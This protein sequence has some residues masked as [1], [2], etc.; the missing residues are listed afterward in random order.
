[1]TTPMTTGTLGTQRGH[2]G[3]R[4]A[5]VRRKLAAAT[6]SSSTLLSTA[7]SLCDEVPLLKSGVGVD[8]QGGG[9]HA[10]KGQS[11]AWTS[12][13]T[14]VMLRNI[15]NR[16]TTEEIIE[17]L[18]AWGFE[19]AFDFFY[20]PIDFKTKRNKGYSFLNFCS[21]I[22]ASRFHDTFNHRKLMKYV[23]QK[24]LETQPAA[25]QGLEANIKAYSAQAERVQNP[26]FKPMIFLHT[27]DPDKKWC[28]VSL[29]ANLSKVPTDEA[30]EPASAALPEA[31]PFRPPPGLEAPAS[32]HLELID[33]A[34]ESTE[35]LSDVCCDRSKLGLQ[36]CCENVED[37]DIDTSGIGD[38]D[39]AKLMRSAVLTFLRPCH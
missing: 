4:S 11:P 26:W 9:G 14:S 24:V 36:D 39:Q 17:E 37:D 31:I 3:G 38:I 2:R 7:S 23:T 27:N 34:S 30:P 13:T 5:A 32:S 29:C 10:V 6:F 20:L 21:P 1:M 12:G 16:Y 28:G 22:L 35:C 18:V 15:P 19:G 33:A 25:T 8:S